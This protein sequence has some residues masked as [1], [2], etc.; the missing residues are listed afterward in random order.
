VK[1]CLLKVYHQLTKRYFF[2]RVQ[3]LMQWF[4]SKL[5]FV[6]KAFGQFEAFL[7]EIDYPGYTELQHL[8]E[9]EKATLILPFVD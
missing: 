1:E 2:D 3:Q 5:G 9:I 4:S 6:I 7:V 8:L